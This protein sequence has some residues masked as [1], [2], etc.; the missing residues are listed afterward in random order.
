[1]IS[2]NDRVNGEFYVA[3]AYNQLIERGG[4][5]GVYNIG[6]DHGIGMHGIGTPEDLELFINNPKVRDW[7]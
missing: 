7:I 1:M 4:K 5:F 3:P 2:A 6:N